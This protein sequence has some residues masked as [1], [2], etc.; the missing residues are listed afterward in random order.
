MYFSLQQYENLV[1]LH[2]KQWDLES[3]GKFR[4]IVGSL[5]SVTLIKDTACFFFFF[6]LSQGLFCFIVFFLS[7]EEVEQNINSFNTFNCFHTNQCEE[8]TMAAIGMFVSSMGFNL[9]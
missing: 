6:T 3:S 5:N 4:N 8:I 7:L 1:K 9:I 2:K